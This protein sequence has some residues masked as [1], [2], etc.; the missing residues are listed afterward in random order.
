MSPFSAT[1]NCDSE[2]ERPPEVFL[3][4]QLS[5]AQEGPW[6]APHEELEIGLF[7]NH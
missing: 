1:A 7:Y 6:A 3:L 2:G 5:N 4:C